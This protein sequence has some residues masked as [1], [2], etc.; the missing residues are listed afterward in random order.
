MRLLITL[1]LVGLLAACGDEAATAD[2]VELKTNKD[3]MSYVV[4]ADHAQQL[5]Q[6][7]N[8]ANYDKE[9]IMEGFEIGLKDENAFG[10]ECNQ[11]LQSM[12]GYQ[13]ME[14]DPAFKT[15]GSLC[16][17]KAL[18]SYFLSGW[19]QE[20]FIKKF[21]L[22]MVKYGFESALNSNDTLVDKMERD[23]MIEKL[24]GDLNQKIMAN[25]Q[26]NELAFFN[27]VKQ[28][29][30]TKEIGNGI[31]L[32]TIKEGTGGSPAIGDDVQARYILI[33]PK[34]DTLESSLAGEKMGQPIPAFSLNGVIQGWSI[35]FPKLKKGGKYRLYVPQGLAYGANPPQGSP[36]ERFSPLIFYVELVNYGKPGTLVKPQP[37]MQMGM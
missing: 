35:A 16:I 9:K 5:L 4:G 14:F 22:E 21:D 36:I 19:K 7:K 18:G 2:A 8:F 28:I 24:I 20:N 10:P 11:T 31:Y 13:G 33:S 12:F 25:A 6:D 17:G 34:G 30:N 1:S 26:K 23:Q 32:E 3:K 27:K 29:K 15:E 37:Q